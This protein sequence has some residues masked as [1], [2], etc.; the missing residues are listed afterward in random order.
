M[1]ELF[2]IEKSILMT[3]FG[4]TLANKKLFAKNLILSSS[5]ANKKSRNYYFIDFQS[6]DIHFL[7]F[8]IGLSNFET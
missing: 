3:I 5:F 6:S 4:L 1:S 8:N 7:N 2:M